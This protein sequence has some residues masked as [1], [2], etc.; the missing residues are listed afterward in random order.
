MN[1][2]SNHDHSRFLT[3]TNGRVGRVERDGAAAAEEGV[4]PNV[5]R[6]AVLI[7]MTWPGAPCIYYGDEAGMCGWTDPDNRRT[8]P[9]GHEDREM[10]AYHKRLIG[11]HRTCQELKTGA[12]RILA[13]EKGALAYGRFLR[14][15]EVS[16][17][18]VNLSD[19]EMTRS[20]RVRLLG[21]PDGGALK[22]LVKTSGH[23][24]TYDERAYP[25]REGLLTRTLGRHSAVLLRY[26]GETFIKM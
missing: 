9:W 1:Q 10:L 4:D 16:V 12:L 19:H 18:L 17:V 22:Q 20:I 2:L 13:A 6:I 26:T 24:V 25:V 21:I 3:R 7:Q 11:L 23:G 15:G 14:S 5:M 8:Y